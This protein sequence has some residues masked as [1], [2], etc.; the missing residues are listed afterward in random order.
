LEFDGKLLS[1]PKDQQDLLNQLE[2]M[3]GKTHR[4]FS[5]AV[6]YEDLE[7]VWRSVKYAR[8]QM[9]ELSDDYLYDYVTRNWNEV[10]WCVGGYQIEAEGARL[11]VDVAGDY[12]TVLGMPLL[13][14]LS[15]LSQRGAIPG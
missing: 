14:V 5:A 11:F 12:F 6:I 1:K 10:R 15:Y 9:R 3:R 7:P 13:D 4:L 2:P 8:M